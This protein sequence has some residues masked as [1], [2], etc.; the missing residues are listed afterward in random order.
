LEP[1]RCHIIDIR[2]KGF[3]FNTD[4]YVSDVLSPAS[5]ILC[6]HRTDPNRHFLIHADKISRHCSGTVESFLI[7]DLLCKDPYP[8]YSPELVP[9]DFR[10]LEYLNGKRQGMEFDE[11]QQLLCAILEILAESTVGT[12][13]QV[14]EEWI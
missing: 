2:P 6:Q 10:L 7:A 4:Y 1:H 13:N 3:K 8:A 9:L 11:P 14:F 5:Q 12:L